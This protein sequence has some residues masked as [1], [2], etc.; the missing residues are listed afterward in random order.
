MILRHPRRNIT[1]FLA[2]VGQQETTHG[3]HQARTMFSRHPLF[4]RMIRQTTEPAASQRNLKLPQ[5]LSKT[6]PQATPTSTLLTPPSQT[7]LIPGPKSGPKDPEKHRPRT[8]RTPGTVATM[9][10]VAILATFAQ[11]AARVSHVGV[12]SP[13]TSERR[14]NSA[15]SSGTVQSRAVRRP[16]SLSSE[17]TISSDTAKRNTPW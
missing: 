15:K 11:I 14:T 4:P 16:A 2:S 6:V 9:A 10:T 13:G 8:P 5:V 7:Q 12:P 17:G 1:I 3:S